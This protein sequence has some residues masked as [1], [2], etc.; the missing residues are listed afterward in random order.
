MTFSENL[1]DFISKNNENGIQIDR[2]FDS[3]VLDKQDQI[4]FGRDFEGDIEMTEDQISSTDEVKVEEEKKQSDATTTVSYQLTS[5]PKVIFIIP[6]AQTNA[7]KSFVYKQLHALISSNTLQFKNTN[8]KWSSSFI[9]SDEIRNKET[10]EIMKENP[11]MSR[12]V[13][14]EK[15]RKKAL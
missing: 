1:L 10:L 9:S 11:E 5:S 6:F 3:D 12:D 13:A 4:T 8:I 7:G 15:A 2:F 14:F